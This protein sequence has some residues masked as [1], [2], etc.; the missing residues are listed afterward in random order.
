MD[1]NLVEPQEQDRDV[2]VVWKSMPMIIRQEMKAG[3][4]VMKKK[5]RRIMIRIIITI[6]S[7]IGGLVAVLKASK[8]PYT[9]RIYV[10]ERYLLI[11]SGVTNV[12]AQFIEFMQL[13]MVQAK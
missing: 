10:A 3:G 8:P 4:N 5:M 12:F 2:Q 1:Q 7:T 13:L 6:A 11:V 9:E